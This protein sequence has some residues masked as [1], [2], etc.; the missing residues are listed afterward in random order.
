MIAFLRGTY[1]FFVFFFSAWWVLIKYFFFRLTRGRD[2]DHALDIRRRWLK[3][4][5]KALGVRTDFR[6]EIPQQP[7]LLIGNHRSYLDPMPMLTQLL[8]FPVVKA[9]VTKWPLV[10][11]GTSETGVIWVQRSSKDSRKQTREAMKELVNTTGH[12]ILIFPEGTTHKEPTTKELRPGAFVIAASENIPVVPFVIEY[13][14]PDVAWVGKDKFIPHFIKT[15]GNKYT[16]AVLWYGPSIR[17]DDPME[18]RAKA[19]AWIDEHLL[20]IQGER[21]D[22]LELPLEGGKEGRSQ[23]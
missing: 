7:S 6:G 23:K 12:H 17:S 4:L 13:R 8:A 9:E 10:G 15:F 2:I 5:L 18:L 19:K 20:K 14:N 1:R 21:K 11:Y 22:P 3:Y 16:D